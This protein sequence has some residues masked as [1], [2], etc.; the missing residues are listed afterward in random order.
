MGLRLGQETKPFPSR[1]G[2]VTDRLRDAILKGYLTP[3]Q[4][5]EQNEVASLLGVS[6]S[7]VR[8]AM[9]VL[10][11]EGLIT[12]EPHHSAVVAE[13]SPQEV[14][15][16]YHVRGILEGGLAALA[17]TR[18]DAARIAHLQ[19]V[20]D[21]ISTATEPDHWLE[22]N[23]EFHNTIYQAAGR[24]RTLAIVVSLRNTAAL[25]IRSFVTSLEH[26][27]DSIKGHRLIFEAL[28]NADAAAAEAQTRQHLQLVCD[29]ALVC[30][31]V[32]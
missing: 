19:C 17:A 21:E 6:R 1:Q 5:L 12:L 20:L 30:R 29:G 3:G 8:E 9:Q 28:A 24:P 14:V 11:A 31:R 22:L 13:L 26:R 27:E 4:R 10:A 15:E 2:F 32:D 23:H 25:F 7:P 16:I 18:M